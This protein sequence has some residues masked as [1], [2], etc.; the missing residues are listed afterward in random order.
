M[1]LL[2]A[3]WMHLQPLT[4]ERHPSPCVG[5]QKGLTYPSLATN[6][7]LF[8]GYSASRDGDIDRLLHVVVI[9]VRDFG[10][11]GCMRPVRV[12]FFFQS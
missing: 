9:C 8:V 7:F 1:T 5:V 4:A 3:I 11:G 2:Q 10:G 6:I 12:G